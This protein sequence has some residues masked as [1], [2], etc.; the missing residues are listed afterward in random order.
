MAS[1][2]YILDDADTPAAEVDLY[3]ATPGTIT[4]RF[5]NLPPRSRFDRRTGTASELKVT[6]RKNAASSGTWVR[7]DAIGAPSTASLPGGRF[8]DNDP[9]RAWIV[10]NIDD[11]DNLDMIVQQIRDFR[12]WMADHGQRNKPLIDTEYGILVTEDLGFDYPR[13]RTFM[14]GSFNRF[15]ND[16]VDPNLGYPEDGNRLLQEWFWFALAVDKFEGR[17]QAIPASTTT[18]RT[19]SSLWEWTSRISLRR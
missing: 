8:E 7:V 11:H 15:L 1:L 12:Q 6:G 18:R 14:L 9:L 16:L 13:V 5:T 3:A 19:P 4:R 2:A 10:N 17:I